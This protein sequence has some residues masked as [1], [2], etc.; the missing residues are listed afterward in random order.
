MPA[1]SAWWYGMHSHPDVVGRHS[2]PVVGADGH[3]SHEEAPLVAVNPATGD[4]LPDRQVRVAVAVMAEQLVADLI[5]QWAADMWG[6]YPEIGESD[7]E[8]VVARARTLVCCPSA[9]ARRL[10]MQI[11]AAR[12]EPAGSPEGVQR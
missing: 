1:E 7:W 10:A 12:A 2:H 6:S 9:Q 4:E 8:R 3:G 11:L 5:A